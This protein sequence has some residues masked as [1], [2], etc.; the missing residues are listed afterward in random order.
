MVY[1]PP[2]TDFIRSL[3][4]DPMVEMGLAKGYT[5]LLITA[6]PWP[7]NDHHTSSLTRRSCPAAGVPDGGLAMSVPTR[8]ATVNRRADPEPAPISCLT[9]T[10]RTSYHATERETNH[11]AYRDEGE[12]GVRGLKSAP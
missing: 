10:S 12:V 6:A 4:Y 11:T 1:N 3:D 2:N 7:S 8:A 9:K 5:R